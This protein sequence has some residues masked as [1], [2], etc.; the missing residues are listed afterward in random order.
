MF[1]IDELSF[2]DQYELYKENIKNENK[3]KYTKPRINNIEKIYKYIK[4]YKTIKTSQ[5]AKE[6]KISERMVQRYM[7]YIN[8]IYNNIGYDYSNNEWYIIGS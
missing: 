2:W 5:I 7:K 4:N 6:L 3:T 1:Y 8:E